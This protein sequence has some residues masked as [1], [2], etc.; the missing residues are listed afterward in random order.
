MKTKVVLLLFIATLFGCCCL[1][2]QQQGL[3]YYYKGNP[4]PLNVNSQHFLVYADAEKTTIEELEK[5]FRI[6]ELIE[7]GQNGFFEMQ[8]NVPNGNYDSV[9][10]VLKAKATVPPRCATTA[11]G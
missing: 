9:V 3:F 1:S 6:T 4:I 5:E 11:E 8:I 2:A 7:T 10:N